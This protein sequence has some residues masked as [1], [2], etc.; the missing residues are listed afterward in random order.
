MVFCDEC[1]AMTREERDPV[2]G[3]AYLV[4]DGYRPCGWTETEPPE[5]MDEGTEEYETYLEYFERRKR[6][7]RDG[8][9]WHKAAADWIGTVLGIHPATID[10]V[11]LFRGDDAAYKMVTEQRSGA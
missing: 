5:E 4:C 6:E 8:V 10:A 1:G 7:Q 3:D 9:S 11:A 2:T